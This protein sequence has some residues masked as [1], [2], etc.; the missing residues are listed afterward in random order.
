MLLLLLALI[1]VNGLL[2]PAD[3]TRLADVEAFVGPLNEFIRDLLIVDM[4]LDPVVVVVLLLLPTLW[5]IDEDIISSEAVSSEL[6]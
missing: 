3:G 5:F 4:I 2:V 1:V 6:P